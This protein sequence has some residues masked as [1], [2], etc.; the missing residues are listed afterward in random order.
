MI[1]TGIMYKLQPK[2]T[3]LN[4]TDG[5]VFYVWQGSNSAGSQSRKKV[6]KNWVISKL[7]LNIYVTGTL[8]TSEAISV[9]LN[10]DSNTSQYLLTSTAV[11]NERWYT[12]TVTSWLW[13]AVTT[14]NYLNIQV[15][16]PTWVTNPTWVTVSADITVI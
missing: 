16:S 4:P 8:W 3:W 1:S 12:L 10:I 7:V 13:I 5:Q 11:A 15:T 6:I 2:A 14:S 9:H